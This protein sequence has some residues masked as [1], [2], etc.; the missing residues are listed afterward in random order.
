MKF[1]AFVLIPLGVVLLLLLLSGVKWLQKLAVQ[2]GH[3]SVSF[4]GVRLTVNHFGFFWSLLR[5]L[6]ELVCLA[7]FQEIRAA[8][9]PGS[10]PLDAASDDR[11]KMKQWRTERNWWICLLGV[12]VW[13]SVWRSAA[14]FQWFW[15]QI[16][17]EEGRVKVA[18]AGRAG[19]GQSSAM[20]APSAP[21]MPESELV[22][23]R[24]SK[25]QLQQPTVASRLAGGSKAD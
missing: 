15:E 13:L 16:A 24:G 2:F 23:R 25:D 6:W 17:S 14:I 8:L 18:K 12:V 11:L 10:H 5:F 9:A 20:P 1:E 7:D 4:G 22:K 3:M 19:A 21:P